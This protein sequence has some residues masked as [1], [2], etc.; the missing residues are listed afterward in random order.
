VIH[1]GKE[2]NYSFGFNGDQIVLKPLIAEVM[3]NYQ[4]KR[5]S[6]HGEEPPKVKLE[7]KKKSLQILSRKVT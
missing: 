6:K 2:N 1:D 7:R 3:R 5:P 4:V